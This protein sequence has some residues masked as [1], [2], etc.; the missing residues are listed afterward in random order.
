MFPHSGAAPY[1]LAGAARLREVKKDLTLTGNNQTLSQAVFTVTGSV[2]ILGIWGEVITLIGSNHTAGHLRLNDQTATVD[3]TLATGI[4]LSALAVGTV[5][6]KTG[7]A[8][9][10]LTL[11]DNVAGA[12]TEP[13]TA[14]QAALSPVML[15]KKTAA[16]TTLDYRYATT[17]APTTGAI[18][19]HALFVPLSDDGNLVAA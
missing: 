4:N 6:S 2:L 10:A 15:I 1:L 11:D 13:A 3:V 16:T 7:L 8:A 14:G 18:R 12:I 19:F 17:N 9:A 5:V